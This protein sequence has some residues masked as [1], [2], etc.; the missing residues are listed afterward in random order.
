MAKIVHKQILAIFEFS[1][2]AI[3]VFQDERRGH[4]PEMLDNNP[5]MFDLL[6]CLIVFAD[7]NGNLLGKIRQFL[8]F[9]LL[10][11]APTPDILH[12]TLKH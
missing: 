1:L 6:K 8:I 12:C 3:V 4:R 9:Y 11:L 5:L 2:R 10:M 7:F